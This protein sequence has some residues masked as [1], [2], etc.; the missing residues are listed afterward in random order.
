MYIYLSFVHIN[1]YSGEKFLEAEWMD[2]D[3]CTFKIMTDFNKMLS[4]ETVPIY[5]FT[6]TMS[7]F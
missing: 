4:K 6:K 2:Q 1:V 5:T 3:I 7:E